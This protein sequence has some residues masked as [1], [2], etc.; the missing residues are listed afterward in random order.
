MSQ[1]QSAQAGPRRSFFDVWSRFYDLPMVQWAVYRP[2]QDAVLRELR[3][4]AARRILDVGCGTGILTARL[5][6]ELEAE[7]VCGFDFSLGMLQQA[8]TRRRGPLVQGDAQHLPFS[9]GAVE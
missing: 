6:H 3:R 1:Q 5:A 2:V 9:P 8:A 7:L 4:P